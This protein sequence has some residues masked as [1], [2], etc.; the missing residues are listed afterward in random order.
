[1]SQERDVLTER[2]K[3]DAYF[4]KEVEGDPYYAGKIVVVVKEGVV[5]SVDA[6]LEADEFTQ[7]VR[8]IEK[9]ILVLLRRGE[10]TSDEVAA[11]GRYRCPASTTP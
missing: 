11:W 7:A 1:M 4:R 2:Q 10:Y 3:N 6:S 9:R 5:G 8:Q